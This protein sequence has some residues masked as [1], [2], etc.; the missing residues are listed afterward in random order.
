MKFKYIGE[1]NSFCMELVAYKI[2]AE[3]G[4]YLFKDDIIT[5][6]NDNKRVIDALERSSVFVKVKESVKKV[7]KKVKKEEDKE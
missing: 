1:D 7:D 5:V 6:P 4:N 2:K 3:H